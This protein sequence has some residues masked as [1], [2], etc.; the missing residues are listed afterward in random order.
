VPIG[1]RPRSVACPG[2]RSPDTQCLPV[3]DEWS[4]PTPLISAAIAYPGP[5]VSISVITDSFLTAT[6]QGYSPHFTLT[7]Y[8]AELLRSAVCQGRSRVAISICGA[9]GPHELEP[10]TGS[11]TE[12]Q[13]GRFGGGK[14]AA[15][16]G[17]AGWLSFGLL[18][19]P[20]IP[21]YVRSCV[22]DHGI[23]L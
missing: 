6:N 7:R 17:L 1:C 22:G 15:E 11:A 4:N 9:R 10:L 3:C 5:V 8:K 16:R 20:S 2:R 12:R 13:F 19:D 14:P 21:E 18:G 23:D